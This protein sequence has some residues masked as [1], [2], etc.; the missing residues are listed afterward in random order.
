MTKLRIL[1]TVTV[2]VSSSPA[3]RCHTTSHG[4]I[5]NVAEACN[6]SS[7]QATTSLPTSELLYERKAVDDRMLGSDHF[8]TS[9][10]MMGCCAQEHRSGVAQSELDNITKIGACRITYEREGPLTGEISEGDSGTHSTSCYQ[11][12]ISLV[13]YSVFTSCHARK[14]ARLRRDERLYFLRS[15]L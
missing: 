13:D 5:Q 1:V 11:F 15:R 12:C 9:Y 8:S 3:V 14:D 4:I 7:N 2:K 10:D 6:T